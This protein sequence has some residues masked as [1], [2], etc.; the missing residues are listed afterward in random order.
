MQAFVFLKEQITVW[1]PCIHGTVCHCQQ[2]DSL[3]TATDLQTLTCTHGPTTTTPSPAMFEVSSLHSEVAW[4]RFPAAKQPRSPPPTFGK[5]PSPKSDGHRRA[6]R[7]DPVRRHG[8]RAAGDHGH[9]GGVP[10]APRPPPLAGAWFSGLRKWVLCPGLNFFEAAL[11]SK[12]QWAQGI[13]LGF[14]RF[15]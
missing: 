9:P 3:K 10:A 6:Q 7:H 4:V 11:F 2:H 5:H 12:K 1:C 13:F 8:R 15:F 14:L